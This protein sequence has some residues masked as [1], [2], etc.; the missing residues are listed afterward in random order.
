MLF[1][2][3][4][5]V[6]IS[7]GCKQSCLSLTICVTK[8]LY[9]LRN[10][11]IDCGL[12]H[13]L[14]YHRSKKR[15]WILDNKRGGPLKSGAWRW[16]GRKCETRK[17]AEERLHLH[18]LKDLEQ[19]YRQRIHLRVG[20]IWWTMC[21]SKRKRVSLGI[22]AAFTRD[23]ELSVSSWTNV[24]WCHQSHGPSSLLKQMLWRETNLVE[25]SLTLPEFSIL[26]REGSEEH[27]DQCLHPSP[28]LA[29]PISFASE[30]FTERP[31]CRDWHL[32]VY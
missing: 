13:P 22:R 10:V 5:Y 17:A 19:S 11:S 26:C 4:V 28:E 27:V 21:F 32:L 6:N 20:I 14:Q 9:I 8:L 31:L 3:L 7:S 23:W 16:E 1:Y 29:S 15:A 2:I 24:T 12:M 25:G 30:N 18:P